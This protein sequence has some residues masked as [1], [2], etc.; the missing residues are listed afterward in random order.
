MWT[1]A[2][3]LVVWVTDLSECGANLGGIFIVLD[4]TALT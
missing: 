3:R 1:N 2:Q 4:V